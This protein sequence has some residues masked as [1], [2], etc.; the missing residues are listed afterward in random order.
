LFAIDYIARYAEN[1]PAKCSKNLNGN[2]PTTLHSP[3]PIRRRHHAAETVEG[4]AEA[5][6]VFVAALRGHALDAAAGVTEQGF[7]AFETDARN[8]RFG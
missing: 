4:A 1:T 6:F 3:I 7:R 5:A 8:E 2:S